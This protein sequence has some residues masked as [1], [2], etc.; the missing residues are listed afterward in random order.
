M[1][2]S[3]PAPHPDGRE[4]QGN[5]SLLQLGKMGVAGPQLPLCAG[6]PRES[7]SGEGQAMGG[8]DGKH[9]GEP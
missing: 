9:L 8:M 3:H 5:Q 6:N 2:S 4:K 1:G 7:P